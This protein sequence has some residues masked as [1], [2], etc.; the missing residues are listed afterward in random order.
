MSIITLFSC[1]SGLFARTYIAVAIICNRLHTRAVA[2]YFFLL[3]SLWLRFSSRGKIS[4]Q[5]A[6][7]PINWEYAHTVSRKQI[8]ALFRAMS[9]C[10]ASICSIVFHTSASNH[11]I[12][13]DRRTRSAF[14]IWKSGKNF[15]R[16]LCRKLGGESLL[17]ET[18][19]S[20]VS[21]YADAF[22]EERCVLSCEEYIV[23]FSFYLNEHLRQK[24]MRVRVASQS[25][26]FWGVLHFALI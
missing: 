1:I 26:P 18:L 21:W 24:Y 6:L 23:A 15:S 14:V 20:R 13:N 11:A 3:K 19:K 2:S 7:S 25:E 16:F 17:T 4:S 8:I 5:R 12:P 10:D 9:A 22:A